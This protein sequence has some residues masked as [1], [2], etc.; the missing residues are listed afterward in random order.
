MLVSTRIVPAT[1]SVPNHSDPPLPFDKLVDTKSKE[2]INQPNKEHLIQRI[3]QALK[4][5]RLNDCREHTEAALNVLLECGLVVL[6]DSTAN[7][8]G[9]FIHKHILRDATKYELE[10]SFA[11]PI[12]EPTIEPASEPVPEPAP[13][14]VPGPTTANHTISCPV[15]TRM[16]LS[17][18]AQEL[19]EG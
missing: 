4:D 16:T 18:L 10:L 19:Q 12:S 11:V 15:N 14:P 7:D 5:P 17:F 8:I 3:D 13:V 9:S 6:D 2:W 1:Q